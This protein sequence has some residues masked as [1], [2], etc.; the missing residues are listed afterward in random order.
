MAALEKTPSCDIFKEDLF[1][2]QVW[3]VTGGGTG[4]GLEIAIQAAKLGAH[5]AI[6]GRRKE[7]LEEASKAIKSHK[8]TCRVFYETC[9]SPKE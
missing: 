5:L 4:I 8:D 1:K 6:C 9:T 3:I 2:D 7:P